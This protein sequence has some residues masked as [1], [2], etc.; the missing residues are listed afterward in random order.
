MASLQ[1]NENPGPVTLFQK[2]K[3]AIRKDILNG[4]CGPHE[5]L[6]SEREM[7]SHFQVS[8]ITVRQALSELQREGLVFKI[9]GKG[10][11]VSKPKARFDVSTLRGFGEWAATMGQDAFSRVID[12]ETR[13]A[14]PQ[15][16]KHLGLSD[17][18]QTTQ[19]QR[20]R[21]L[22]RE[23]LS[24]D[25]TH[26]SAYL[27][28]KMAAADLDRKDIIDV[29]ENECGI[30]IHTAEVNIE[31]SLANE[32]LADYLELEEGSPVLKIVRTIYDVEDTAI[33]YE[34][35]FYRGD[36]FTCGMTIKRTHI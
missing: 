22:N 10:T 32:L 25:V 8:R 28:E 13:N 5:K 35:L 33:L 27:G 34:N 2:V 9:N 36:V 31:A 30:S 14:D 3:E 23:P 19:I 6:P 24:F 7:I 12:I 1:D 16:S 18:S 20:L 17:G 26:A 4:T 15:I 29:L 11:Y 21:F